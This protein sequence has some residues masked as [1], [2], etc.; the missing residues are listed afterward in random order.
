MPEA[1]QVGEAVGEGCIVGLSIVDGHVGGKHTM[2]V[3]EETIGQLFPGLHER[4]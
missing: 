4:R 2:Q 1:L 3:L